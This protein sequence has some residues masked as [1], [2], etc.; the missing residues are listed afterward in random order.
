M[1][2]EAKKGGGRTRGEVGGE[3]YLGT[4]WQQFVGLPKWIL[5]SIIDVI[6]PTLKL[7]FLISN[8]NRPLKDIRLLSQEDS[9]VLP[10]FPCSLTETEDT[11]KVTSIKLKQL[12]VVKM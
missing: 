9:T 11:L 1:H 3:G 2:G 7:L 10:K 12:P 5:K 4:G 8:D 6:Y